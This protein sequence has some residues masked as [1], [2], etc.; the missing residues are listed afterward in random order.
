[1]L[2]HQCFFLIAATWLSWIHYVREGNAFLISNENTFFNSQNVHPHYKFYVILFNQTTGAF[3]AFT[4]IKAFLKIE[5]YLGLF[6]L[7]F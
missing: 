1:M 3:F 7:K 2:R 6:S 5:K 4:S